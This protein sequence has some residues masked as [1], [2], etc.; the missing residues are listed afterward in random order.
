MISGQSMTNED[1]VRTSR[2]KFPISFISQLELFEGTVF[3]FK[4]LIVPISFF[5]YDSN[6]TGAG[7]IILPF[8]CFAHCCLLD[9]P[10]RP[11]KKILG[12][13]GLEQ[14]LVYVIITMNRLDALEIFKAL[15]KL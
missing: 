12:V 3:H 14:S 13:Y 4:K 7:N 5:T 10:S 1:S 8:M 2:I 9:R 11:K 15:D 6:F